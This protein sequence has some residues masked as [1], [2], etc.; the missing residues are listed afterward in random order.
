MR[1]LPR[2]RGWLIVMALAAPGSVQAQQTTMNRAFD[3]ERRGEFAS[4]A[5]LYQVLL[6]ARPTD[7]AALLGLERSLQ[8][9]NRMAELAAPVAVALSA[10]PGA[11]PVY[12][13]AVRLWG[14]RGN[15]DSV[16]RYVDLWAAREPASEAP[17]Q[18]WGMAALQARDRDQARSAYLAGRTA[19]GDT[20]VL[21]GELAQLATLEG[22]Y[23]RAVAEW[24][25]AVSA[26][27]GYRTSAVAVLGQVPEARRPEIL[28]EFAARDGLVARRIVSS[29]MVRWGAPAE[30]VRHL[31]AEV[32]AGAAGAPLLQELLDDLR[33]QAGSEA[34][35]AR[36]T[37][38]EA[39]A[40]R[41]G[42]PEAARL[43]L[44]AAQS[45]ADGGDQPA[46]R[47]M[48]AR[49]ATTAGTSPS[50]AASAASTLVG[51]L[52]GE[53]RMEE[54]AQRLAEVQG[55]VS[56]EERDRLQLR[57]AEGWG[58]AGRLDRAERALGADSTVEALALRGRIRLYRGDLAGARDDLSAAGPFAGTR[59][60]ATERTALLA[61]LQTIEAESFPAL[62]AALYLL[63]RGDSAGAAP[64]LAAEGQRLPLA[65]GG[66]EVLLLAARVAPSSDGSGGAAMP[67]AEELLQTVIAGAAA[68]AAAQA[69][70]DLATRYRRTGR[71]SEALEMLEHLI[72]TWPGSAIAPEAR[73]LMDRWKGGIPG[74]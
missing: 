55:S 1:R 40:L 22:D 52:I 38:L 11:I 67:T 45:Y 17:W 27:P 54:A 70:L 41:A 8:P 69:A 58:Q 32:P 4:A 50:V 15:A 65:E 33:S 72:L 28:R 62:G 31:M 23:R 49:L 43:Y 13:I 12:G 61:L 59:D 51:V 48:L 42:G 46:A 73:R 24:V 71:D 16:R 30:G 74:R 25:M 44:E 34:R 53:G 14:A 10:D 7:V 26:V 37:L 57:L 2:V 68:G 6:S 3:F 66:G 19:L 29:L 64:A 56:E 35:A 60:E 5:A 39:L 36:G 9:L 18:E 21:A 47:R 63:A 20:T